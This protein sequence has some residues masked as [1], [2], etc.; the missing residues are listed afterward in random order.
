MYFQK[1]II[2]LSHAFVK[3]FLMYSNRAL[4]LEGKD[5][6]AAQDS[7]YPYPAQIPGGT[8]G[9]PPVYGPPPEGP[10]LPTGDVEIEFAFDELIL[11]CIVEEPLEVSFFL[12]FSVL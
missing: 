9:P 12:L 2:I 1:I 3:L 6:V 10:I 11:R 4:N 8:Y 5:S 7:Y